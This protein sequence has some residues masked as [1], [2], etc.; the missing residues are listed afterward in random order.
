MMDE[1]IYSYCTAHSNSEDDELKVLRRQTYIRTLQPH[2][3]SGPLQG[4]LL[5]QLVQLFKVKK[6]LEIGT[7]TGYGTLC[8][9]KGLPPE[10]VIHT[11]EIEEELQ[12]FHEEF[13]QRSPLG[14]RIVCHYGDANH[15]IPNLENNFDFVFIDA[16]KKDYKEQLEMLLRKIVKGGI[17]LA[18]NVLWKGKVLENEDEQDK[19]TRRIHEFNKFVQ[20]DPRFSNVILPFRDGLNLIVVN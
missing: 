16:G 4:Q 6:V 3:L 10:G 5:T 11:I 13:F 15:V 7:F 8:L 9:A 14:E 19:M 17:I 2:M 18:D 20:N 1:E 12:Y